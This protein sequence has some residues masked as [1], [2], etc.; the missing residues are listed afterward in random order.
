MK[1]R[2]LLII[3][4][5]IL[6]FVTIYVIKDTYALFES[7]KIV[8][9]NT[10]IAKWNVMINGKNINNEQR[11]IIDS[12]N[13]LEKGNVKNGKMAPGTEGYFDIVIEPNDTDTSI[14][15]NVTFD[16][17]KVNGS[18][19]INKIEEITSGN[20]IMTGE[21]TYSKVIT[22]DEIKRGVTNTI[23]VYI[24][25]DNI[26]EN[27]KE[28]SQIGLTKNNFINIPVIVEVTQYLGEKILEYQNG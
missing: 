17:T 11:F 13:I 22:L 1:N 20:L 2:K 3:L 8:N 16:F 18:F 14:I 27:N 7:N 15:Y 6:M 25:W 24:K 19:K 26:E 28:D 4:T 9:T 21:S 10:N 12:I 23:R 5:I